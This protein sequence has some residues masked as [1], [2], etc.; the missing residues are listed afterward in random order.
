V[1]PRGILVE[2][3]EY[4][5]IC[6]SRRRVPILIARWNCMAAGPVLKTVA[7]PVPLRMYTPFVGVRCQCISRR[8][9]GLIVTKAAAIALDTRKFVL[10][11]T[12]T[13]PLFVSRLGCI[14][15]SLNTKECGGFAHCRS[16][17]CFNISERRRGD[18]ALVDPLVVHW[19]LLK[20]LRR[21][22][23][24]LGQRLRRRM[25]GP[26]GDQKRVE[27]GRFTVVE[28]KHKLG[29]VRLQSL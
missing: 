25:S 5:K 16:N 1:P 13:I 8:P 7:R 26:V 29:A 6:A 14:S 15:E 28:S 18:T 21:Y 12:L 4:K 20:G 23:E 11:A 3:V 27:F 2:I 24:I 9:P 19:D 17:L 22:T 10:S